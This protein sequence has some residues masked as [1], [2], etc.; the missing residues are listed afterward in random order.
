MNILITGANGY[1][2][3]NLITHLLKKED[4]VIYALSKSEIA[5]S[6]DRFINI[7]CDLSGVHFTQKLPQGIDTVIHL[8]QSNQYRNFP[9]GA[10]DVFAVNIQSTQLLL[11]WSRKNNI[12]KFIFSSTG[13]VY[14][15]E[16]K[17]LTEKD[18]CE[19]IGYYGAS[20]YAAEQ[21]IHTYS[22]FFRT[23][24][25]RIFGVYGPGQK[26]MTI[27]N[28]IERIKSSTPITLAK[29]IGLN[30]TPLYISDC[31][32]MLTHII[33]NKNKNKLYNLTGN[34]TIHLGHLVELISKFVNVVPKIKLTEDEPM[35]LTGSATL[36]N[37]DHQYNP[38]ITIEEGLKKILHT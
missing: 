27:P 20:K 15:P 6:N 24:V 2:G 30:F 9:E 37:E 5:I 11:E 26:S 10:Q 33:E 19:P 3:S 12:S 22:Q 35:Y 38:A 17:L 31:I 29:G 18:A 14:K 1:I 13:N 32:E 16:N 36:F 25:V 7:V 8:A 34:E 4:Y 21:L 28:I 23:I